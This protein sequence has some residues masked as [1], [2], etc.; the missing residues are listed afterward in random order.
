MRPTRWGRGM[1]PSH[2]H[3]GG[4]QNGREPGNTHST[5]STYLFSVCGIAPN[6]EGGAPGREPGYTGSTLLFCSQF[7][8]LPDRWC[9]ALHPARGLIG[10]RHYA[11]PDGLEA[12]CPTNPL[13]EGGGRTGKNPV[14]PNLPLFVLGSW[15]QARPDGWEAL[16]PTISSEVGHLGREPGYAGSTFFIY[17]FWLRHR[18][19][20]F[21]TGS[22]ALWPKCCTVEPSI[23]TPALEQLCVHLR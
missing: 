21:H 8:A 15:H 22:L 18:A 11:Q 23:V 7:N 9:E 2:I 13:G 12:G 14:T 1:A 4:G 16:R 6:H 17:I 19:Q 10:L 5:F 3:W 20:P